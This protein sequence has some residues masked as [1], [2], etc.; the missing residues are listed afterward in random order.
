MAAAEI[1]NAYSYDDPD[2]LI[3]MNRKEFYSEQITEYKKTGKPTKFVDVV[4]CLIFNSKGEILLQKRSST[5]NHNPGLIDK[6]LGGHVQYGDPVDYTLMVETV[7]ELQTPSIVLK[8]D[9]DLKR[10]HT[11]LN[12]YLETISVIKQSNTKVCD[13]TKIINGE[14][15][16]IGNRLYMYFGIYNGRIKPADGEA[17]GVLWY[18]LPDLEKE[19][20]TFP[21]I[22]TDDL[23]M[24]MRDYK[25]EIVEFLNTVTKK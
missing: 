2:N 18:A 1:I 16:I 7:Q 24:I 20:S 25:D 12:D 15:L 8:D 4:Q 17:Q 9:K 22:F 19:M 3:P 5:K 21:D 23:K 14:K 11:L 13:T 6:S 10:T